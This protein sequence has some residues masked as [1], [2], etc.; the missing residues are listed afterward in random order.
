[1]PFEME[2]RPTRICTRHYKI[3]R[4]AAQFGLKMST[5]PRTLYSQGALFICASIS[6]CSGTSSTP[7]PVDLPSTPT[8]MTNFQSVSAAQI[9]DRAHKAAGGATWTR[10]K[11]LAM[12]GYA[13][14]YKDGAVSRHETHK[15]WRVYDAAKTNAHKADGKVRITSMRD[16]AAII[17][18]SYDGTA[19][20][21]LAG[22]Q[23][24]SESDKRWASNFGF[25]VIRHA[26]DDGYSLKRLP[27]DLID[28]KSAYVINVIDPAGGETLFGIAQ[29]NAA[30]VKVGFDTERGW[31]ERIY[32]NF[33]SNPGEKWVQPGRVRL[34]YNGIKAN[35]VIWERYAI[36][37]DLPECL[38]VLPQ[39]DD[40]QY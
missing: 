31:H 20:Y 2:R 23:P 14:F 11:S 16:G 37:E 3:A 39:A 40:C 38:F 18:L 10:P 9:V 33:Y 1:M 21:T 27:D 17:N 34:Y 12:E 15:M 5:K 35:E 8:L 32:S 30:I 24:K 28:G 6:G 22:P 25:G 29:E 19:T 36:N 7:E 13:V 4:G 26:L